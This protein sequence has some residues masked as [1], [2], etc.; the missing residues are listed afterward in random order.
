ME[1]EER[2][3]SLEHRHAL[4]ESQHHKAQLEH[5]HALSV[6]Q[7]EL[8]AA[9]SALRNLQAQLA[10]NNPDVLRQIE[11]VKDDLTDLATS[12]AMYLEY[13]AV[14]PHRQTIREFVCVQVYE[15]VRAERS[16]KESMQKEAE[17]I[18]AKFIQSE[19]E[20]ER[21]ARERD[22]IARLK[23]SYVAGCADPHTAGRISCIASVC[24]CCPCCYALTSMCFLLRRRCVRV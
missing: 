5:A 8:S 21:N 6:R 9:A 4:L 14:E 7:S 19:D 11:Y 13:K 10:D 15:L 2:V 22:Q 23:K 20:A 16:A 3:R 1:L 12:E 18:R 17:L 24:L